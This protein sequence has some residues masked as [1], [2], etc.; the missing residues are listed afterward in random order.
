MVFQPNI[1]IDAKLGCLW[2]IEL[3]LPEL[4]N[5]I[6]SL[7]IAVQVALK[8]TNGKH[9]LLMVCKVL[10]RISAVLEIFYLFPRVCSHS[11]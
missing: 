7:G 9:V 5:Q 10:T 2:H 4:L 3:C 6:S 1:V 11:T 8:R